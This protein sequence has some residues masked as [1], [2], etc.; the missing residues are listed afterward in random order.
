MRRK[1]FSVIHKLWHLRLKIVSWLGGKVLGARALVIR[2]DEILLIRHTYADG[3][4]TIGGGIDRGETPRQAIKRELREEVGLDVEGEPKLM[5]IY[6]N[7]SIKRGDYVVLYVIS[8]VKELPAN[9][10]TRSLE[11]AEQRWFK[12]DNLP[13]DIS[14]A[15]KRRIEEFLGKRSISESWGI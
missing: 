6:Y 8:S 10:K 7:G 3:W 2:D 12:L 9:A 14:P 13:Q 11:I 15:T 1:L 5:G 4:Y